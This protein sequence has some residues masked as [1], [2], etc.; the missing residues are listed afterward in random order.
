VKQK[1]GQ[2][3]AYCSG[4][5]HL[6][7]LL[8]QRASGTK[9]KAFADQHLFAPLGISDV[10][11]P[12]DPQGVTRGWGDL[13]LHPK[14]MAKIGFLYLHGGRWNGRQIV[15]EKWI[16]QATTPQVEVHNSSLHYGYGW[17]LHH[18]DTLKLYAARGRG[19][20][21]IAV[22]PEQDMVIVTTG[23]VDSDKLIRFIINAIKSPTAITESPRELEQLRQ[24]IVAAR[25]AP[26]PQKIKML[27]SMAKKISNQHYSLEPNPLRLSEFGI[28]FDHDNAW[29]EVFVDNKLYDLSIG[30][31]G[32]YRMTSAAPSD[33][34]AGLKGEWTT[35]NTFTIDYQ[36][37]NGVNHFLV[38]AQFS[39]EKVRVQFIDPTGYYNFTVSGQLR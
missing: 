22:W 30:L 18:D 34:I 14:D 2:R 8:L 39:A 38:N 31:D 27:A 19:G 10:F 1:P 25:A 32:Q 5:S 15:S 4:N 7:S 12:Q 9:T 3:F 33:A 24:K 13:Q 29:L 21:R 20:Q 23:G 6:L 35:N 11:W 17:W 36:E 26:Q 37:I 16:K 28:K